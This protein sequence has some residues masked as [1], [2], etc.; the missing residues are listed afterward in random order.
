M[1]H[2]LILW[3]SALLLTFLT[4]YI[5]SG[6]SE[7]YPIT[8]TFG[9]DEKKV[10][11]RF[12]KI[13]NDKGDYTFIIRTDN[14]NIKAVVKWKKENENKWEVEEMRNDEETLVARIPRQNAG[15]KILYFA[16]IKKDEKKYTIPD[17]PVTILFQGYVPS[18]I[19]FLSNFALLGG[20]LLSF[21]TG[22]EFF[23]ENQK[24][25]KLTLFT[26]GF[27]FVYTIAVTPLRKSYELNAINNKVVPI[28]SLFDL[29]SVL[30]FLLWIA[31]MII[32]FRVKNPKLPAL[33]FAIVNT[34]VFLFVRF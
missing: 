20:L 24:I 16:E 3:S 29:Q 32:V 25:K 1:K 22:L 11:Y 6:T 19:S 33:V 18:M 8:G 21:R 5:Q 34:L 14:P 23:N 13:Y 15:E 31:A 28:T 4:G 12:E 9:I 26:A 17:K 2:S 7:Y 27:F 10:S 30:L